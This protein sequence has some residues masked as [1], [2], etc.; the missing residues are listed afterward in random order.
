MAD[1]HSY[2]E[3]FDLTPQF[4]VDLAKLE[5]NYRSI[6]SASHPDRFVTAS[7][8]EKLRS[9][10]TATLANEAY[11]TL[12]NPAK[13]AQYLLALLGVDAIA[14]TNTSMPAEFL[15]QQ[16]EWREAVD[17]AKQA[18]NIDALNALLIEMHQE[19]ER[20]Q[21][22]L[23]DLIDEKN[24]LALATDAT[25]KLIFIDKVCADIRKIIE[26]LDA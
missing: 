19:A 11:Q 9:M 1:N 5:T 4:D 22:D 13:R 10:Q 14:E 8:A 24:N 12:K 16:M 26:Q 15:M 3:L 21:A 20:L 6:Q 25:R 7:P 17:D 23:T 18:K 2:F